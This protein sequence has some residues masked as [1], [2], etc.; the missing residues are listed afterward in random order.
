MNEQSEMNR[1]RFRG[2]ILNIKSTFSQTIYSHFS[3]PLLY[4]AI[5]TLCKLISFVAIKLK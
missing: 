2:R 3:L 4:R 5:F 1:N